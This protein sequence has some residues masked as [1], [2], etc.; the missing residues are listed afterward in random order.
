M[1]SASISFWNHSVYT[2]LSLFYPPQAAFDSIGSLGPS[3]SPFCCSVFL[4]FRRW[5]S[6]LCLAGVNWWGPAS[7]A[8]PARECTS[9]VR[10]AIVHN[11]N[12]ELCPSVCV[13]AMSCSFWAWLLL[14]FDP[15][16]VNGPF[17]WRWKKQQQSRPAVKTRCSTDTVNMN[18]F[19]E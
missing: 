3:V 11:V 9:A 19:T 16:S 4:P 14:P 17:F 8:E 1:I 7:S 10:Q 6:I 5:S 18:T 12:K 15:L 13:P 2:L